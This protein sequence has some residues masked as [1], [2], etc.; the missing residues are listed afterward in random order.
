MQTANATIP[1]P[2]FYIGRSL[3][4]ERIDTYQSQKLSLLSGAIGKPDTKS[5]WYSREHVEKLLAEIDYAGGD[6]VRLYFGTYESGHVFADQTC[7]VMNVTREL[8]VDDDIMHVDVVLEKEPDFADRSSVPREV[9]TFPGG[10]NSIF[11]R[12]FNYGSP[13]PPRCDPPPSELED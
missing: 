10:I 3:T 8:E 5:I 6:G 12:D 2:F 4:R 13:C 1:L 7:I 9:I 11:K